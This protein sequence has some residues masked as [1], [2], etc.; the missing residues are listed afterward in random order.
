MKTFIT[1]TQDKFFYRLTNL[2]V[3]RKVFCVYVTGA[4]K[5]RRCHPVTITAGVNN[6][7]GL[8]LFCS[9][10]QFTVV[11]RTVS[12]PHTVLSL[13]ITHCIYYL[14]SHWLRAYSLFWKSAKL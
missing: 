2:I 9:T 8:I 6:N 4:L 5:D 3:E 1:N 7:L 13:I 11:I 14:S 10:S 12:E